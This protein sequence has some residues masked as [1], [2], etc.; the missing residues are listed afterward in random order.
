MHRGAAV[1]AGVLLL[2]GVTGCGAVSD[3][4]L[5]GQASTAAPAKGEAAGTLKNPDTP[6]RMI[7][8]GKDDPVASLLGAFTGTLVVTGKNCIGAQS[9]ITGENAALSWGHGWTA[10]IEDGMAVVYDEE[11]KVF[12]REGD[13]V[14]LGGGASSRFT[15]HPCAERSIFDVNN[16]PVDNAPVEK[17]EPLTR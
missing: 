13:K 2:T 7:L 10:K 4:S 11:G 1:V 8:R 5:A 17:G 9:D 16:A 12:A 6:P 15:H 3:A 14:S